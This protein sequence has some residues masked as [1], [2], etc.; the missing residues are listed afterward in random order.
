MRFRSRSRRAPL[1]ICGIVM[2][3]PSIANEAFAAGLSLELFDDFEYST[4]IG[5]TDSER[6]E[7]WSQQPGVHVGAD[8]QSP[9]VT[10]GADY[11][12]RR[13]MYFVDDYSDD[14]SV[15]GYGNVVWRALPDRLT[16]DASNTRTETTISARTALA[17]G[18]RQEASTTTAGG[19]LNIGSFGPQHLDLGYHYELYSTDETASDS[20]TQIASAAYVIPLATNRTVQLNAKRSDVDFDNDTSA[21]Y[22]ADVAELQLIANTSDVDFDTSVGYTVVDR[23]E[24]REDVDSMSGH[25]KLVW[26]VLSDATATAIYTR[27]FGS[28]SPRALV[29]IPQPG[30]EINDDSGIDEVYIS[31]DGELSWTQGIGRNQVSLAFIVHNVNY[32]DVPNDQRTKGVNL[33]IERKLRP[34]LTGTLFTGFYQTEFQTDGRE[35]DDWNSGATLSYDGFRRLGLGFQTYYF[36]RTSDERLSEYTEWRAVFSIRYRL[37]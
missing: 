34:T 18:N 28:Q 29:G 30:D 2:L 23:K 4:N 25:F 26:R 31:D 14:S 3:S 5:R 37:R 24:G 12:A 13:R 1:L 8:H 19:T 21:D 35:D 20:I 6:D 36:Q 32:E 33:S 27:A 16:L 15:T 7:G 22:I 17:P 10:L 11:D 9:S